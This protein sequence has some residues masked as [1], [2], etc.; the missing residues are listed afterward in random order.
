[1]KIKKSCK[2]KDPQDRINNEVPEN[3]CETKEWQG[4]REQSVIEQ[5]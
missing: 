2:Y 3:K 1:M 5:T 4:V